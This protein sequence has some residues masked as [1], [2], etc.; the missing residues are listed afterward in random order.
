MSPLQGANVLVTGGA[1]TIGSTLVDALLAAGVER[2]DVLDNLV[3]GRLDNLSGALAAGQVEL[4]QGSIQDRDLVHDLTRGKDLVF[5]QAAIRITQCAEEPRLALEVL[6]DGT[7][8]VLE[9]AAEHKVAKLVAASSASVYGMA[10]EFPTTERHHHANNDTFYGA[11]K[12]FNEG[13]ARSF[14]AMTGLDYVMLRYFNVYG[15]R[16]DVHGLYT[17]VLVRWMERIMDGQPPLIFGDG[18][19]TMDFIYT[20]DVARANVLAAASGIAEGTYN[21]ASGTETSLLEMARTLLRVMGSDLSVDHG[22]AR[23]V[24][25]VVRR[26][27]DTSAA[28]RDLGFKAEVELDE[29]LRQLV[30]WWMPLRDEIAAT[31]KVGA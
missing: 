17:E 20:A 5:H 4:V 23:Q 31:R 30:R 8:N 1:G 22:P 26:L 10:E 9:A 15:P 28:A 25:S 6:V 14:R 2:I 19:Q 18:L 13:M 29:G 7:F 21:V 24:N 27:A 11:A 3:R 12:S 16:M